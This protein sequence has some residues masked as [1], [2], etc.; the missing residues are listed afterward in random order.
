MPC[1]LKMTDSPTLNEN[2]LILRCIDDHVKYQW[3]YI[4]THFTKYIDEDSLQF[5]AAYTPGDNKQFKDLPH[6]M[7][8]LIIDDGNIGHVLRLVEE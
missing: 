7:Y 4:K 6:L 5:K 8:L 3:N 2:S 1:L